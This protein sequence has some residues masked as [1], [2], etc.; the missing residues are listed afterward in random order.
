MVL[1]RQLRQ[2]LARCGVRHDKVR[3]LHEEIMTI[4]E[5]H[6]LPWK[7]QSHLA[8]ESGHAS[9]YTA[10]IGFY[11][12]GKC[13]HT[14]KKDDFTFGRSYTH[15]KIGNDKKVYKTDKAAVKRINEL[16]CYY[17]K[18]RENENRETSL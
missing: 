8:M 3:V 5:L 12:I 18:G 17:K 9:C 15:Y 10:R 1:P 7:M 11:Q 4:Q 13:V 14:I 16:L 6:R 2:S